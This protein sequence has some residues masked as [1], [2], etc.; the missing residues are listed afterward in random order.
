MKNISGILLLFTLFT[1]AFTSCTQVDPEPLPTEPAVSYIVNYGDYAGAK[2]TITAFDKETGTVT[3][4]YYENVNGV[5]LVSNIQHAFSYNGNIYMLGNNP[6]ELFWVDDQT[7]EQ[8]ENGIS[9][10]I[11][12]PRFGVASGN[13]LYV[14]CWGGDIWADES[15]SYIAKVNLGTRSVEEKISLPGGPEGLEVAHNKLYAALNYKDSVAVIDLSTEAISYIET[16]AVTSYFAKDKNDNLYVSLVSTYSDYSDDTGLGYIN[17]SSDELEATYP[18]DGV[19]TSYVNILAP[20]FNFE[21]LYVMTS[22]YD[23]NWN[24]NGAI[25]VFDVST[26]SF[27]ADLLV[28]DISGANGI[29]TYNDQVFSFIAESVTANGWVKTYTPDGTFVHEFET[30]KAPFLLLTADE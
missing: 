4:H 21:K 11:V 10:D 3:N 6:D 30:G 27:G 25:A 18:L 22:A 23:A 7:F 24:L 17:T 20:D 13:Y 26:K 1:A 5:S 8:H 15:V 29:A 2:S 12:K 9:S 14:S 16:P 28:E 19:S